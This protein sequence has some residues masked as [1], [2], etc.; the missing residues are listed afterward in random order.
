MENQRDT[1]GQTSDGPDEP[2]TNPPEPDPRAAS[3]AGP[4]RFQL[5]AYSFGS[6]PRNADGSLGSTADAVRNLLEAIQLADEVGLDYF[7][8]GEHHALCMPISSPVSILNAAAAVTDRIG[9]GTTVTVLG[10]DD[11]VRVYQQHATA[12]AISNGRVDITVGR[13]SSVES[14]PLFGY[15]VTD[16]DALYAAKLELLLAVNA[17]ERVTWDG[18]FRALPLTD[19]LVV[20]RAEPSL[21]IWLG[22]GGNPGST[23]RAGVLGLPIFYGVLGGNAAH[24]S[25]LAALYRESFQEAGHAT[26]EPDI[27]IATHGFV[28]MDGALAKRSFYDQEVAVMQGAGRAAAPD[29]SFFEQRYHPGGMVFAGDPSEVAD[30]LVQLHSEIGHSRHIIQMDIGMPHREF[31]TAIELLGTDVAP[32]VRAAIG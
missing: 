23:I 4:P 21:K 30:R 32:R 1:S 8:V 10:T 19:A 26:A 3:V 13:G 27:A 14:F 22:T 7:G 6:L 24:W 11:P 28:G 15:D 20:P 9:L 16:Y 31:L 25:R 5:G 2:A 18:P 29:R 17:D 12:H